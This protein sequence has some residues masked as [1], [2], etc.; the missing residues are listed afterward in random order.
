MTQD[1]WLHFPGPQA[2]A[3]VE[4]LSKS[5]YAAD[6]QGSCT[7]KLKETHGLTW[8]ELPSECSNT[9]LRARNLTGEAHEQEF[10]EEF[11]VTCWGDCI[12][13]HS[14]QYLINSM[15]QSA[16]AGCPACWMPC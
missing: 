7:H 4:C 8:S 14:S 16:L 6:V 13:L 9:D 1:K 10:V 11:R 2:P 5:P 15:E 3:P 12:D